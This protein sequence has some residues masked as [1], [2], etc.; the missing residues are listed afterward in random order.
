MGPRILSSVFE[1]VE[2]QD[3]VDRLRFEQ[4]EPVLAYVLSEGP[5]R[6]ALRDERLEG[7]VHSLK[8]VLVKRGQL[9]VTRQKGIFVARKN[10]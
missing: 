3:Y 9:E 2:R 7:F 5:V 6:R 1:T 4:V 8:R 10:G